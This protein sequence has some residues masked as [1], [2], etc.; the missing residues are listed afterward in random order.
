[1]TTDDRFKVARILV[2][3]DEHANVR[4]LERML[5]KAGYP[6]VSGA[7]DPRAVLSLFAELQ[8]DLVLLDLHMPH[9]DGLE[10]LEQLRAQVAE[11]DYLPIVVLTANTHADVKLRALLAGATDFLTKPFDAIELMFR[12]HSLLQTRARYQR[13]QAER[14]LW[15]N[16]ASERHA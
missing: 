16:K 2:V 9:V 6:N 11:D 12:I 4:L 7:T 5:A 8:P 1:M 15:R 13:L 14:D 10:L 3:D